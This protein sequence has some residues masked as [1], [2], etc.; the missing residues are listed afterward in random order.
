M[1]QSRIHDLILLLGG[2]AVVPSCTEPPEDDGDGGVSPDDQDALEQA[3]S[4]C[5]PYARKVSACYEM[6]SPDSGYAYGYVAAVGFCVAS[7]GYYTEAGE[8]CPAAYADY[9]ACLAALDC[10]EIIGIDDD[11]VDNG[12]EPPPSPCMAEEQAIEQSC[13]FESVD[14]AQTSG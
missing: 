1:S 2:L 12:T 3:L 8:G 5:K 4:V 6:A 9:F 14:G 7:M 10:E 11:T 13:D